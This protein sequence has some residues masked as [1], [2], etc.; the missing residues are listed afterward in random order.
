MDGMAS[1]TW[2]I[3][4]SPNVVNGLKRILDSE[5][6]TSGSVGRKRLSDTT[7]QKLTGL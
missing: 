4:G 5:E 6:V 3:A 7:Q 1:I 2:V